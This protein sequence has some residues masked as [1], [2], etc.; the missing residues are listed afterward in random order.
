MAYISFG[1]FISKYLV[2]QY[3]FQSLH[4]SYF[5]RFFVEIINLDPLAYFHLL[6]KAKKLIILNGINLSILSIKI[7]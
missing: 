2:N 4:K 5:F 6:L 3:F 7:Y 1:L